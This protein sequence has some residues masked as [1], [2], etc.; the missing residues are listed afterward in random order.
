MVIDP[1]GEIAKITARWRAD[2]LGQEVA[3]LDPFDCSGETTRRF[4]RAFN[5]LTILLHS[6]RRT[7]VPN[8]KLIADALIVPGETK[9][10]HWDNTA[11]QILAAL[12]LFVA[13]HESF[14]GTRDLVTVW[15]LASELATPDPQDPRRYWLE[16]EM[17]E[18]D[19]G[20]G[21]VRVAA[22]NFYSRTGGE[23]SSVLSNLNKH[24]EFI[25]IPCIQEVLRGDSIDLRDLKR[26]SL[27]LYVSLPA[28]RMADLSGWLRLIVQLAI[29]AHEE[30]H[31]QQG[32]ATIFLLEEFFS[33]GALRC[34]E[35]AIGQVAGFGLRM[36]VVLQDLNQLRANFPKNFETFIANAGMLQVFGGA[37]QT[38][39]DYC[40]KLLGQSLAITRSTNMP[41]FEQAA[42]HAATG[43]SW[44]VATHPLMT[45]E[46]IGRYFARD[47]KKLRQLVIR[48]GYR[49][50]ILQRAYYD[51]HELFRGKFDER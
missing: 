38:T 37:D 22:M 10:P 18:S 43:E 23:F 33:L 25:S 39:L 12:C 3:M 44:S 42:K 36:Y 5:P 4:R 13:K 50:M 35:V 16:R 21:M 40:S 31:N 19:A 45:S 24:L 7:L 29:A 14:A 9:D 27:A 20:E 47:D 11:K 32:H 1:K 51:K 46:E 28:M 49:P 15:K 17:T 2:G 30:E 41:T 34:L 6:D 8:T 26:S 48:P